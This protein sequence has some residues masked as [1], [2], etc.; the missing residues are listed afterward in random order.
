MVESN[1]QN[2]NNNL[3]KEDKVSLILEKEKDKEFYHLKFDKYF[4]E[5]VL[6]KGGELGK[7]IITNMIPNLGAATAAG[8]VGTAVLKSTSGAPLATRLG[9]VAAST[10]VTAA[11]TRVGLGIGSSIADKTNIMESIRN[12]EHGLAFSYY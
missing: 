10:L 9:A 11:K 4:A 8:A 1:N 3:N 6:E 5:M 7:T 2:T 12:S